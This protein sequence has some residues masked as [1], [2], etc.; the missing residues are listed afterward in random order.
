M[1]KQGRRV[2]KQAAAALGLCCLLAG[3]VGWVW[4]RPRAPT[5]AAMEAMV[6]DG[7]VTADQAERCSDGPTWSTPVPIRSFT[8]RTA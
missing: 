1:E 4:L 2:S 3:G 7:S 5:P 6:F 8:L